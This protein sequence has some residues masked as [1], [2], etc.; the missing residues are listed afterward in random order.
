MG[1]YFGFTKIKDNLF[2]CLNPRLLDNL[3]ENFFMNYV[4]TS[5]KTPDYSSFQSESV[6]L[7]IEEDDIPPG[8][9]YLIK[10]YFSTYNIFFQ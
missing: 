3:K 5:F 10:I 7:L 4:L 6:S 2:S 9:F 1:N 8:L